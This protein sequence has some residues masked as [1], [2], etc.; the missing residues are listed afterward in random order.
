MSVA[1]RFHPIWILWPGFL[2]TQNLILR[3]D[4][5]IDGSYQ[6]EPI[7]TRCPNPDRSKVIQ[8]SRVVSLTRFNPSH[9]LPNP[10]RANA[11]PPRTTREGETEARDDFPPARGDSGHPDLPLLI[12]SLLAQF[13]TLRTRFPYQFL[14]SSSTGLS[15]RRMA[16][17]QCRWSIPATDW[18]FPKP[19]QTK[20]HWGRRKRRG[21]FILTR[22]WWV[23]PQHRSGADPRFFLAMV[24]GAR[25]CGDSPLHDE[26]MS[27]F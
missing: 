20:H 4:H 19:N 5:A 2:W 9:P 26:T 18:V 14:P 8:R 21:K 1:H 22:G 16:E 6:T 24:D 3:A 25:L 23:D 17:M 27:E 15:P 11:L 7:G 13:M 10:R 12:T